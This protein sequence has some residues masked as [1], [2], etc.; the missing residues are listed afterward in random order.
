MTD[1][2]QNAYVFVLLTSSHGANVESRL[3]T[4]LWREMAKKFGDVKFC[5]IR[6]DLCIEGYPDKNTP[7]ILVYKDGDIKKQIVT[8][9]EL[10]GTQTKIQG[11]C[12]LKQFIL[13]LSVRQFNYHRTSKQKN[14]LITYRL[15]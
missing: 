1:T 8:L 5:Q 7:T 6:G 4:E 3:V 12:C 2:S 10:Q 11:E 14:I 15:F 13:T 9:K